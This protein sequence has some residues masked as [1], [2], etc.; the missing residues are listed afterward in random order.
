MGNSG[1]LIYNRQELKP[2]LESYFS[3]SICCLDPMYH[4][5]HLCLN[6]AE[7]PA[8]TRRGDLSCV[9]GKALSWSVGAPFFLFLYF[10]F[11]WK[12]NVSK[13]LYQPPSNLLS[14]PVSG[15]CCLKC[16]SVLFVFPT[17]HL[18]RA[19]AGQA[20]KGVE[21]NAIDSCLPGASG[22]GSSAKSLRRLENFL[23]LPPP[24]CC[25]TSI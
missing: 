8:D 3:S 7:L 1:V 13:F 24:A 22:S 15:R 14:G 11:Y 16:T 20:G 2:Y 17:P 25:G 23:K 18:Q 9:K 19:V 12:K 21:G 5:P 4:L 10:R 6:Q